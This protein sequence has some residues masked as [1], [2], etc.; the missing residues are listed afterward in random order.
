[1]GRV[2]LVP[3]LPSY[4]A[5]C[6]RT[7]FRTSQLVRT[8]DCFSMTFILVWVAQ[9]TL[10]IHARF[11][12]QIYARKGARGGLTFSFCGFKRWMRSFLRVRRTRKAPL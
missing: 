4:S 5:F 7:M 9:L 6:S 1:M 12:D 2:R 11:C 3:S 8:E 10:T